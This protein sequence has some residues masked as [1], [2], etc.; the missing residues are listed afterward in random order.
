MKKFITLFLI[1][2][3]VSFS[4]ESYASART[5]IRALVNKYRLSDAKIGIAAQRVNSGKL[6]Y[7]FA[8]E[9]GMTPASNNKIFTATTALNVLPKS[10][11]FT[12]TAFYP[13]GKYNA[14]VV[15]GNLYIEFSGDPSLTGSQ[16][17]DLIAQVKQA[18]IHKVNG[19]VIIVA[20][21]FTGDYIPKGWSK[22]DSLYCFA[23]PASTLNV[24]KNCFVIKLINS[25]G[26][27][28]RVK[29]VL[30]TSNIKTQN[31]AKLATASQRKTCP[32]SMYMTDDNTLHLSGCLPRKREFY[33]NLAIANPALKT[34][35]TIKDFIQQVGINVSGSV[36]IGQFGQQAL[37]QVA[38][39]KS[40]DLDNLLAHMLLKSD[41]LYAESFARTIGNKL[42][43][44][45]SIEG[46]TKAIENY[47]SNNYNINTKDLVMVDGSGLSRL[48]HVTP[49]FMVNLLTKVYNSPIGK[50]FYY[51]LPT[52]GVDGTLAYR[53]GGK[54]QS[55][56]HAKTGTLAGVSSLSGYLLTKRNHLISFSI[57]LNDLK[58]SQRAKA[59]I[60]Q[61]E[62]INIF[63]NYL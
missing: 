22:D 41:N 31:S 18:G 36:Q 15:D 57:I 28:T 60:F 11:R 23:A 52:S 39:I 50:R 20:N 48:D 40:A 44:N 13:K 43:H 62:V 5:E 30:N 45:G 58:T 51:A 6:L 1:L 26:D 21:K 37:K 10:F 54:L 63:Y 29:R 46:S 38:Q 61:D 16:L 24:N 17:Y 2:I 53:M 59:R 35:D 25:S 56:V 3:S 7:S 55:K 42:A 9:R 33:L 14:G 34:L 27:N 49:L 12:T 47:L 19:N 4:I 32:F 8:E